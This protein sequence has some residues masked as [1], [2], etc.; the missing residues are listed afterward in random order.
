[1]LGPIGVAGGISSVVETVRRT[2][3]LQEVVDVVAIR[4]SVYKDGNRVAEAGTV[5]RAIIMYI[6]VLVR[7]GSRPVVV[8]I[9]ASTGPS[10][11]R[12]GLFLLCARIKG[13]RSI[14]H[15]HASRFEQV[16]GGGASPLR[17]A[18][19]MA[20]IRQADCV[21]VLCE[22]WAEV[23][24]E[25]LP[26]DMAITVL[27]NPAEPVRVSRCVSDTHETASNAVTLLFLGIL[28]HE[29][30]VFDLLEMVRAV[31]ANAIDVRLRICGKGS[32]EGQLAAKIAGDPILRD[33]V[34]LV[35]WV[36]GKEKA[37][38]YALA[39]VFILPSYREGTPMALLEAMG[40]GLPCITTRV[41]GIPEVVENGVNGIMVEP[42]DI[43]ALTA[44]AV[45]LSTDSEARTRL[46][47]S[48]SATVRRFAP[49]HIAREWLACYEHVL[50]LGEGRL[51]QTPR[52]GVEV[53]VYR[54]EGVARGICD[55]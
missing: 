18:L 38:E 27:H 22:A 41:G 2:G 28:R 26:D 52:A 33:R 43:R 9:H 48:A 23:V 14:W 32:S 40:Y 17:R 29:K 54:H 45:E 11:F 1:M 44:A 42:G 24:R 53:G 30:G 5:A 55:R 39:D 10:L 47:Q 20:V 37:A 4:T 35:G 3:V 31:T 7:S 8:H 36:E 25:Y 49:V 16:Y 50:T 15:I 12:K 21:A 34:V 13:S 19:A 51:T 46:G 6:T